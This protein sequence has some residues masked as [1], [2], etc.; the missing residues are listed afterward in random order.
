LIEYLNRQIHCTCGRVHS[1]EI[2][3]VELGSGAA[4]KLP[5]IL[6]R[7]G[8]NHP[9]VLADTNTHAVLGK[10]ILHIL[11]GAGILYTDFVLEDE[12]VVPDEKTIGTVLMQFNPDCD[13]IIAVGSGTINDI[14][15]YISH[16]VKLPYISAATAPSMD[17]Y[18]STVAPLITASLKTTYPAHA[19]V[20]II[21]DVDVLAEAPL[22]MI[23]AGFGDIL[24]KITCLADWQLSAVIN[25]E[26]Y[27]PEIAGMMEIA[28][29]NTLSSLEGLAKRDHQ[30]VYK[31]MEA[32]ILAGVAMSFA[33]NS[34]PASGSEHHLSHFWE[35]VLL[36][37]NRK[38]IL[39]G[40]KVGIGTVL[41]LKLYQMLKREK[42]DFTKLKQLQ[43]FQNYEDW[44]QSVGKAFGPAAESVI[45]LEQNAG[46]N[47]QE[48]RLK[49]IAKMEERWSEIESIIKGMP[50][51]EYAIRLLEELG[52]PTAPEQI[53]IDGETVYS[54][55]LYAKEIRDRY[56]V[57]QLLWDLGLLEEFAKLNGT[58]D[59]N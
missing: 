11:A 18:A 20:A 59:K 23:A 27:C 13:V 50:E 5:S 48:N 22:P 52:G 39:H 19:P 12:E 46:K 53:G 58:F 57:L 7:L 1:A 10:K 26:Y 3:I 34:R 16:R 30:A 40:T 31:L 37:D 42:L 9:F 25:D 55:I 33:G 8:F 21:G 41:V 43:P 45:K 49:R 36:F 24:G 15:R 51:P 38:Q 54:S 17:G 47:L 29:E 6:S 32:L 44:E 56:T 4:A 35:M 14:C 28:L 2:M